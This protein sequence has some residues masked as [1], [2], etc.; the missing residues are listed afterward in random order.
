M[1]SINTGD[2][3]SFMIGGM[4][5]SSVLNFML[6]KYIGLPA[7]CPKLCYKLPLTRELVVF[8]AVRHFF[9]YLLIFNDFMYLIV[10]T[11]GI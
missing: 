10:Q 6:H 3:N 7:I 8:I 11:G 2:G 5:H 4:C 9:N 1:I